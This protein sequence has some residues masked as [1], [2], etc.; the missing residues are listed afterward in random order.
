MVEVRHIDIQGE[1]DWTWVKSD[2]GAF[3]SSG[4]GPM[5]DWIE[6]HSKKYFDH[7][8]NFN[9]VV[10][11]GGNCGMYVRFYS[12]KFKYVYAFEPN[13]LSFHC[14]VLNN[15]VDN[16]I[17]LNAAVGDK[18]SLVDLDRK[19]LGNIGTHTID[20]SGS[21]LR[22][23]MLTIDSLGLDRCDLIQLDVEG[24]ESK[25]IEGAMHT[26]M[27][28]RP[29]I[30]AENFSSETCKELMQNINYEYVDSSFSDSIYRPMERGQ[31]GNAAVC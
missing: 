26:I 12:K 14:M 2:T 4:N 1:S 9:T 31:D 25:A 6:G 28:Y 27:T 21:T 18:P 16:V 7:V 10:T 3:G 23:P 24:Y 17:K 19:N 13:P 15:Q 20:L 5:R 30:V 11:A 29:I 8:K 22:I